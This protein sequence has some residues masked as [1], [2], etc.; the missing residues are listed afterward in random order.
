MARQSS[1]PDH[2]DTGMVEKGVRPNLY[3]RWL[4]RRNSSPDHADTGTIEK[5]GRLDCSC[6]ELHLKFL[7]LLFFSAIMQLNHD[8]HFKMYFCCQ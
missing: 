8:Q 4:A 3:H 6:T 5:E 2:A 7:L 1:S